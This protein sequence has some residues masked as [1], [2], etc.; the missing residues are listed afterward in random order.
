MNHLK[1]KFQ[2]CYGIGKLNYEFDF[3]DKNAV[4]IYA[5][6]GMMKT[7]FAKTFNDIS[8]SKLPKDMADPS[9]AVVCDITCDGVPVSPS[10]IY[11]A[12][13]DDGNIDPKASITSLLA[14]ENLKNRYEEIRDILDEH[15][16]RFLKKLKELSKS[17][18]CESEIYETFKNDSRSDYDF[19]V[20]ARIQNEVE[21]AVPLRWQFRY[22]DVFDKG[23][24]VREFIESNRN[25][26]E[27]YFHA[28]RQVLSKSKFFRIS[29]EPEQK[30]FGTDRADSLAKS[31]KDNAFFHAG[32]KLIVADSTEIT[33]YSELEE[34]RKT[35]IERVLLDP[36]VKQIFDSI[37][38]KLSA[39]VSLKVFRD[40][41]SQQ[42]ELLLELL[43]YDSFKKNVWYSFIA[44]ALQEYHDVVG[45]FFAHKEELEH[46]FQAAEAELPKWKHIIDVFNTRFHAPFEISIANQRDLLLKRDAPA[47]RFFYVRGDDDKVEQDKDALMQILSKG[48]LRAF[49]ILQIVFQIEER[50][51]SQ[52]NVLIFDDISDSFDYKNKYAIIEYLSDYLAAGEFKA[53]IL[54]HNFDFYRTIVQRLD[55]RSQT[56]SLMATKHRGVVTLQQAQGVSDVFNWWLRRMSERKIIAMVPF[57]RNIVSYI[58]GNQTLEYVVL[59]HCLHYKQN[60]QSVGSQCVPTGRIKV[61]DILNLFQSIFS[62][63][64]DFQAQLQKLSSSSIASFGYC[65]LLVAELSEIKR[66]SARPGFDELSLC[67]KVVLAIGIRLLAEKFMLDQLQTVQYSFQEP[68]KN[69]TRGLIEVYKQKCS[70]TSNFQTAAKT[71]DRVALM[72]PEQIHLNSFMYEPLVDM[73][74]RELLDLYDEVSAWNVNL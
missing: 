6:N 34:L 12:N 20:Y 53:I 41:I 44:G 56:S 57:A 28:Y 47:L 61:L 8:M 2:H 25:D 22:N 42:R 70:T 38:R 46:I 18:D 10:K 35:E 21:N 4:V 55:L 3:S 65:Q 49:V 62:K 51:T 66:E 59:T 15:K 1:V 33:S 32:H 39:N 52:G 73:L 60:L 69:Q 36:A 27:A 29:H 74:I 50:K 7:S 26:L 17:S 31:V 67:N 30:D 9:S 5:P 43:D 37:D 72:T 54:T 71:L 40:A 19:A 48:E 24:K 11:V 45:C 14:S 23:G 63:R 16:K 64:C 58:Q 68:D 13:P